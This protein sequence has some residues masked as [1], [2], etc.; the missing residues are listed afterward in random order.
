MDMPIPD[1][2]PGDLKLA[3]DIIN[4][5]PDV[6]DKISS[7]IPPKTRGIVIQISN[8]TGLTLALKTTDFSSGS[9]D[10]S[11][12]PAPVVGPFSQTVFGVKSA[13]I[14]MGVAGSVTYESDGIDVLLCGF[15]NPFVGSN[16]VNVTLSGSRAPMLSCQAVIGSGKHAAANFV[17][18][19]RGGFAIGDIVSLI[20]LGSVPGARYL[21]GRTADGTVGLAPNVDV[22][23][24]GARWQ[25]WDGGNGSFTLKSLSTIAGPRF[26]DGRS[27]DGSVG[28]A[29]ATDPP[30]TGTHWEI[31]KLGSGVS[32][33]L[34]CL[35]TVKGPRFLDGRTG[36]ETAGLAPGVDP[37]FSGTHWG[38]FRSQI[39]SGSR[40]HF[41][42]PFQKTPWKD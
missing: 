6:I 38:I 7:F 34:R 4:A 12:L 28:L 17:L 33:S 1:A 11:I 8:V 42:H 39:P 30:F 31:M 26:L 29:A 19:D 3:G 41:R 22:P 24:A 27:A 20:C 40:A 18:F 23:F 15:N 9:L 21:D 16:A 25:V 36:N 10:S 2:V 14:A 37:P 35:G 32:F 13:S 5:A